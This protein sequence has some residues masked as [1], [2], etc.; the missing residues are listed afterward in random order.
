MKIFKTIPLEGDKLS[1][2]HLANLGEDEKITV[3]CETLA[4]K[5]NSRQNAYYV[6]KNCPRPDGYTYKVETSNLN[7]TVTVSLTK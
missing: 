3:L 6:R 5:D 7:N 2:E 1:A 4:E